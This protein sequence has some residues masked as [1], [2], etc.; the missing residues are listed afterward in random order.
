MASQKV[1]QIVHWTPGNQPKT[2]FD[3]ACARATEHG[4][5]CIYA[6][7]SIDIE[8]SLLPS[9]GSALVYRM[10]RALT[11]AGRQALSAAEHY[12]EICPAP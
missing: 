1:T 3:A 7:P 8:P 6:L 9:K 12:S 2:L 4:S 10:G 5:S 11:E